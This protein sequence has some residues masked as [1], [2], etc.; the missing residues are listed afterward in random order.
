[1]TTAIPVFQNG[2]RLI[3]GT[4]LN[5]AFASVQ[6]S[7]VG[8]IGNP[9]ITPVLAL[10]NATIPAAALT[11][12]VVARA[13]ST[14]F[15]TDTTDTAANIIASLPNAFI[16]QSYEATIVNSTAFGQTIAAGAGVTLSGI[17]GIPP[18]SSATFLVTYTGPGAV[19]IVGIIISAI[20]PYVFNTLTTV[21]NG[22]I[23]AQQ[24]INSFLARTGPVANFT[25]TTDT[26]GNIIAAIAAP[27]GASDIFIAINKT[28]FVQT[29]QGGTGVTISGG[30]KVPPNSSS[31]YSFTVTTATTV[32]FNL[33]SVS[34][35]YA[36]EEFITPLNTVGAATITGLG[37]AG[38]VTTRGGV[39][40]ANFTDTT[41]TAANIIAGLPFA[42]I[43]Q[44]WE[45]TYVN[46]TS[47]NATLATGTGVTI[48]G[49][50]IVPLASF[51][52][53]L[54]QYTAANTI[55]L[56]LIATGNLNSLPPA[57]FSTGTTVTTFTAGQIT[58]AN[59]VVY[60]NTG[61]TPGSI[62]SRTATQM[63]ADIPNAYAGQT[64]VLRLIN[65][66]GTG[67]WTAPATGVG[68]VTVTGTNTIA[69]NTWRDYVCTITSTATPA[70]TIQ[71]AGTG[72]FS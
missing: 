40:I 44:S 50:N 70:I 37:I 68:G 45:Y 13:G 3:D 27:V 43:G 24:I 23:T 57:Q 7:G 51:S 49:A 35:N 12:G 9:V 71:N 34:P 20:P 55:V 30:S 56:T 59:Y 26:A 58:G 69:A 42:A 32:T 53:Y 10:G 64:W 16:G 33:I 67:T 41:D 60:T 54:V 4:K 29:L 47:F 11:G 8:A 38:G 48:S 31:F 14:S 1:M 62:N 22:T 52:R 25:D 63:I 15:F 65:G 39:Q 61:A 17:T 5:R 21:G 36:F 46:N 28:A 72:T 66:Q 18:T 19:S 2:Y 6:S